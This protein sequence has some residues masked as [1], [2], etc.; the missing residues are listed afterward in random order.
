M[1][2]ANFIDVVMETFS[3]TEPEDD[4]NA[5]FKQSNYKFKVT[6]GQLPA[7]GNYRENC[8]FR[9]QAL[10]AS[11]LRGSAGEWYA[12]NINEDDTAHMW[13]FLNRVIRTRF[14]EGRNRYR[15][16][17]QAENIKPTEKQP[18][19]T[20]LQRVKKVVDKGWPTIYVVV[21]SAAQ[22]TPADNQMQIRRNK[23]YISLG[24]KRLVPNSLKQC[25]Y[26]R[27]Q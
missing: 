6:L 4:T 21:A 26:K 10:S 15:F 1:A 5:F 18:I 13:D 3:G 7:P 17:T 22:R 24:S 8:L 20:Y 16:Q 23:K 9:Q 2:R 27:M 25:A 14:T 11:L 12:G 19:Q